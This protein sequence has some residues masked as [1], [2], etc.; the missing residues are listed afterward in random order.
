MVSGSLD[1]VF[2]NFGQAK[3][4]RSFG[5]AVSPPSQNVGGMSFWHLYRAGKTADRSK[6]A[7]TSLLV[8]GLTFQD[9]KCG[10]VPADMD[11]AELGLPYPAKTKQAAAMIDGV[12]TDVMSISFADKLMITIVQNGRLGQWVNVPLLNDDPTHLDTHLLPTTSDE[13]TLLPSSRFTPRTLLG[14]GSE[15]REIMGHLYAAQ[16]ASA[17]TLK[18]PNEARP[19][20]LGL[21][22]G[23]VNTDRDVFLQIIDLVLK[24]I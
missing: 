10:L 13:D 14:A 18:D 7:D 17:I 12:K 9:I 16:I 2:R 19:L 5:R 1:S 3:F 24:V 21:G 6:A 8:W 15:E 23:K 20:L 11:T 4:C 22:L